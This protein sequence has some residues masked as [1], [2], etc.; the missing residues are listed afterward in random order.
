MMNQSPMCVHQLFEDQ[1]RRTPRRVALEMGERAYTYEQI[2]EAANQ[3]AHFLR[4]QGLARE[5]RVGVHLPRSPEAVV[6]ILGILKAGGAYVP[7]DPA[8]PDERQ[9]FIIDNSEMRWLIRGAA[10]GARGVARAEAGVSVLSLDDSRLATQPRH[11]PPPAPGQSPDDLLYLLY[12]SGSTG[13]PKGVCGIHRA[14][15]NRFLWM[16][17]R[18]PF[19]DSE[20]SA[21]RTTLNFVD[22][23]WEIFGP[24]CRGIKVLIVSPEDGADPVRTLEVVRSAAVTRM[25]VVPSLLHTF[26]VMHENLGTVLPALRLWT[27]S[28]EALSASLLRRFRRG[29]PDAVLLN[30]YGSTEVAGDVT[31]AEFSAWALP[32]EDMVPIGRPIPNAQIHILDEAMRHVPPGSVGMLY[33]GGP[34]LA[35]GYHR[36]PEEDRARFLPNP[37]TGEGRLFR[38]GDHVR[39]GPDGVLYYVGRADNQIKLRGFRI[40]LDE[41]EAVLGSFDESVARVAVVVQQDGEVPETRRLVAFV[42]PATV[43]LAGLRRHAAARLPAPSVPARMVALDALPLTPNGKVDR[44][45]LSKTRVRRTAP[46]PAHLLPRTAMEQRIAALW[47]RRLDLQPIGRNESFLELGGDSISLVALLSELRAAFG[48]PGTF[49]GFPGEP[50][51]ERLAAWVDDSLKGARTERAALPARLELVPLAPQYLDQ[52]I[53]LVTESFLTKEPITPLIGVPEQDFTRFAA[54]ACASSLAGG[55]SW[56]ALA[57]GT[58]RVVGFCLCQDFAAQLDLDVPASMA[59]IFALLGELEQ[60]YRRARGEIRAGEV[61]ELFMTG[62]AAAED[63]FTLTLALEEQA[64]AGAAQKGYQRAVTTCTHLVTAYIAS[65][66]GFSQLAAIPYDSFQFDGRTVFAAAAGL[67]KE[68]VVFEKCLK[69]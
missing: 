4:A 1:V 45:R 17:E 55:L 20:V 13:V 6:A 8:Y 23:V 69:R 25:T 59:P 26:L 35:R 42:A 63:G 47:E 30:L 65:Q 16:W 50:T 5:D 48:L 39:S 67:H 11:D 29:A 24:L 60:G 49:W 54:S 19:A 58:G 36:R 43:D 14:A 34:V 15:V 7:V 28:G 3:L 41:I 64:V 27:V 66:A 56:V 2:N 10:P 32:P 44:E 52:T 22:S 68:A 38:T 31:W 18:Y 33:V 61:V 46:V 40:E 37:F 57:R 53:R 21:H 51:L 12:T 9:R 62:A